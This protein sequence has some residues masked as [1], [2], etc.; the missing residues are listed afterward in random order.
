MCRA[1]PDTLSSAPNRVQRCLI[2]SLVGIRSCGIAK[3]ACDVDCE[4]RPRTRNASSRGLWSRASRARRTRTGSPEI[5]VHAA[6]PKR[7]REQVWCPDV[8]EVVPVADA[9]LE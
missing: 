3:R 7:V 2:G 1:A 5:L 4:G 8:D 6:Y 9:L